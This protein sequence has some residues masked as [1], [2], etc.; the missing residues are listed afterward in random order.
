M[1]TF[2]LLNF[3]SLQKIFTFS[4]KCILNFPHPL[5]PNFDIK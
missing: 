5:T 4:N 1:Y 3:R 2:H